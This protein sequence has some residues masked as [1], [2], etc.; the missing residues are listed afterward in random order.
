MKQ[1]QCKKMT[2]QSTI[3]TDLVTD[4][5]QSDKLESLMK[6][7]LSNIFPNKEKVKIDWGVILKEK[8]PKRLRKEKIQNMRDSK[9]EQ[10]IKEENIQVDL[11][12]FVIVGFNCVI[13]QL[14]SNSVNSVIVNSKLPTNLLRFL[15]PLCQSKQVAVLG[16]DSLDLLTKSVLG[17]SSTVLAFHVDINQEQNYL[18][19]VSLLIESAW[20]ESRGILND[21][22]DLCEDNIPKE[23]DKKDKAADEEHP[24]SQVK[25]DP[26]NDNV[27]ELPKIRNLHLKRKSNFVRAFVPVLAET[28]IPDIDNE[29]RLKKKKKLSTLD[30]PYYG[31]KLL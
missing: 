21:E 15:L 12:K 4:F 5:K 29:V 16:L 2:I 11:Q 3:K 31:S 1:A 30:I 13:K 14:Q 7:K 28:K 17:F 22:R 24:N 10:M 25:S 6:S 27:V 8:L 9:L 23:N 20:K 19:E 18:H 26:S